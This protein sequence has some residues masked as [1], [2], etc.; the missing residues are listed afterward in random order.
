MEQ[1][2]AAVRSPLALGLGCGPAGCWW[3]WVLQR[4]PQQVSPPAWEW[5]RGPAQQERL[6][7]AQAQ[8]SW[9]ARAQSPSA[10]RGCAA[11]RVDQAMRGLQGLRYGPCPAMRQRYLAI[12]AP[13]R[14]GQALATPL[15][16]RSP[17]APPLAVELPTLEPAPRAS[18]QSALSPPPP[19][20]QT[21]VLRVF[22]R[23]PAHFHPPPGAGQARQAPQG[24]GR[25]ALLQAVELRARAPAGPTFS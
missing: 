12:G 4:G 13:P 17:C 20:P 8:A 24:L 11:R 7:L 18:V 1:E 21:A 5:M 9:P 10:Q 15:R 22:R 16:C 19:Q 14:A 3:L 2:M 6:A 25:S 23:L